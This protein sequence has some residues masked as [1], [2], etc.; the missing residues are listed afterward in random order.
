MIGFQTMLTVYGACAV[1]GIALMIPQ[2]ATTS[3]TTSATNPVVASIIPYIVTAADDNQY[4]V[5]RFKLEPQWHIYWSNAGDSGSS[6]KVKLSM[7]TGWT[8][9]QAEFPRPQIL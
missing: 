2:D 7:P 1:A 5:I 9:G 6:P 8:I 4:V 3:A